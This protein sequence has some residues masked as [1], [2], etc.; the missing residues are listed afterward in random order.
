MKPRR[1][2]VNRRKTGR[3]AARQHLLEVNVRTASIRRQ[4]RHRAGGLF[5]KLSAVV[6]VLAL[7][8][9]IGRVA[10][11]KF[12][13]RNPEYTLR[14]L[15][16]D[17]NG[18]I[19]PEELASLTGFRE[20]KNIFRLDIDLANRKL[21]ALPEARAVTVERILPDTVKVRIERRLPLF[22]LAGPSDSGEEAFV[23]GTSYLCDREGVLL[24]PNRLDPEFLKLP[25]LRGVPLDEAIPGKRLE[26]DR[27]AFALTLQEALSEIPE[28]SF[29]IKSIDVSKP[30][31]AVV[32]DASNARFTFGAND[33]PGQLDRLRKLLQHCQE[34]GRRL[35]T[36]NLMVTRNTPVTF[37]V[38]PEA[39][40]ARITPVPESKKS[41]RR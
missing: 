11:E 35:E 3:L 15:D 9:A 1:T 8:G 36:A 28:E 40:T 38:T 20:G 22:L 31:A 23:P 41:A 24:Q 10:A 26:N 39:G 19:T 25:V 16:A 18:V 2:T 7:L 6:V 33:F 5:W 17:L 32:T 4:R 13:F 34:T 29:H 27:L 30:Y 14:H 37:A 21:G 12:L